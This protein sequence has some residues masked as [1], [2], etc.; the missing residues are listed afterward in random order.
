MEFIHENHENTCLVAGVFFVYRFIK[1]KIL[2]IQVMFTYY[3]RN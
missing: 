1:N 2:K 3:A